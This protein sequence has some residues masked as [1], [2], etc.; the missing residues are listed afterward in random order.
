MWSKA[1]GACLGHGPCPGGGYITLAA[2]LY[3]VGT[4]PSYFINGPNNLYIGHQQYHSTSYVEVHERN[5]Y[6]PWNEI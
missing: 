1:T 2:S 4:C 6:E 5:L 3:N